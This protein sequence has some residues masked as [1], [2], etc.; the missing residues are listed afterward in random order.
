MRKYLITI[1]LCLL[2]N[3]SFA[4][5]E[6]FP[7]P[8]VIAE[9]PGGN[10]SLKLF[11]NKNLRYPKGC[12]EEG[13]N[14][15]VVVSFI[16]EKDGSLS[17]FRVMI[18]PDKRLSEEV[19]RIVGLMPKWKPALR[20]KQPIQMRY[21]I[22]FTFRLPDKP[23][24]LVGDVWAW[25]DKKTL[26]AKENPRGLYRLVSL[27][28]EDGT[29]KEVPFFQYKYCGDSLTLQIEV[30]RS[31]DKEFM[32]QMYDNDGYEFKYSDSMN[33]YNTRVYDSNDKG[34]K[35]KWYNEH[36]L[37]NRLFPFKQYITELYSSE[38][39][40]Q[41]AISRKFVDM[42]RM[43]IDTDNKIFGCWHRLGIMTKV[44][45]IDML[46]SAPQELYEVFDKEWSLQ[47]YDLNP[48]KRLR[49]YCVLRPVVYKENNRI[50]QHGTECKIDWINNDCFKLSFDRGDGTI[51]T[52]LW[53]RSGL[54]RNYQRVFG[55]NIPTYQIVNPIPNYFRLETRQE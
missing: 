50:V 3:I 26:G 8:D 41:H 44:E 25:M 20:D 2:A 34:F 48:D 18:S 1:L 36:M 47:V 33:K 23:V 21:A 30:S 43:K 5:E 49:G 42:L 14:G 52:E 38:Y 10:D 37:N 31:T 6:D 32:A 7:K 22:P 51:V 12:E 35:F 24:P 9:F 13:I 39:L 53:K 28:H 11:I 29:K 27:A 54:P 16:V 4:Q 55:T 40:D 17:N 15:R 19:L 45:G 46:L